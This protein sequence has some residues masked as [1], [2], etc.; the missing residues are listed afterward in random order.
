MAIIDS[1]LDPH[2]FVN[3]GQLGLN[4][5]T[6]RSS[7]SQIP[8]DWPSAVCKFSSMH[9]HAGAV[10]SDGTLWVWGSNGNGQLGQGQGSPA[11]Q[12]ASSP[13]QVPGTWEKTLGAGGG[14]SVA[15]KN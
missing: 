5:T 4:N 3:A 2:W 7:P 10:K 15:L 6:S 11:L 8:G 1:T 14:T 13:V 9:R 12:K